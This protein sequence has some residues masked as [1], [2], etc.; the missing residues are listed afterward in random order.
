LLAVDPSDCTIVFVEIVQ[1]ERL[2]VGW[3][4]VYTLAVESPT[5]FEVP[6][7]TKLVASVNVTDVDVQPMSR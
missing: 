6:V 7:F 3:L 2:E 1:Y 5:Y 4:K